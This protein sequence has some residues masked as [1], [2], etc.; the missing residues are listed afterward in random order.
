MKSNQSAKRVDIVSIKLV[1][2]VSAHSHGRTI[3]RP[4]DGYTLVKKME[5]L[6]RKG[7][8]RRQ[9]GTRNNFNSI[10]CSSKPFPIQDTQYWKRDESCRTI[11]K[12]I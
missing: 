7:F 6:D 10:C 9:P 11:I 4:D 5:R 8:P 2:E 12:Q 1:K 3:H